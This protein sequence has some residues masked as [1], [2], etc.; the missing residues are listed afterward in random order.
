M[1]QKL[2]RLSEKDEDSLDNSDC[3]E[4]TGDTQQTEVAEQD[5]GKQQDDGSFVTPR[6]MGEISGISGSSL[7]TGKA[8]EHTVTSP[9]TDPQ[10]GQPI[11]P[12]GQ[13]EHPLNTRT[14]WVGG[15]SRNTEKSK[16]VPRAKETRQTFGKKQGS[17]NKAVACAGTTAMEKSATCNPTTEEDFVVLEKDETWTSPERENDIVLRHRINTE[18]PESL[19]KRGSKE[20]TPDICNDDNFVHPSK[21]TPR[22]KGNEKKSRGNSDTLLMG[23]DTHARTSPTVCFKREMGQR[24]AEVTGSRCQL[25]GAGCVGAGAQSETTGSGIAEGEQNLRDHTKEKV[26][27]DIQQEHLSTLN[28]S[29]S[30]DKESH[31]SGF[32]AQR[33]QVDQSYQNRFAGAVYKRA[34]AGVTGIVSA[35]TKKDDSQDVGKAA[36]SITLLLQDN[37]P[38]TVEECDLIPSPP[39]PENGGC[40]GK[41]QVASLK[42]ESEL[43]CFSAVITPPPLTHVMPNRDTT[44]MKQLD[45][46]AVS[47][48]MAPDATSNKGES[49]TKE[50]PKIKGPPP[51]VPKKPKNPFIKLKTAQLMSTDVQR[52][53]KEHLR[54]EER[55]KRRHTFHFNRDLPCST[56]ANQDMCLLWDEKGTYTVPANIR[57]LSA[58]L[59]PW[60]HLS[61]RHMDDRYGDMIDFE[62]CVRMANL[63]PE[64]E[65][66]NLDMWQ[67]RVFPERRTRSKW[68]PP[69]Y[70]QKPSNPFETLPK[71]E[72]TA[73]NEGERP[74][75]ASSGKKEIDPEVQPETVH[76]QVSDHNHVNYAYHRDISDR[77]TERDAGNG[78]EIGSYKPVAKIIREANQM[79]RHQAE[80][81]PEGSK[82]P[83]RVSEQSPSIKVS[84]MKNAFD[85]PKKSKERPAEVQQSPK[86]GKFL[87]IFYQTIY[88]SN[89]VD[90]HL[91]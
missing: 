37:P 62:Y 54:S 65:T 21:N 75:P 13:K 26:S 27:T 5:E 29:K 63:S 84:Q 41:I 17:E 69:P 73:E 10:S 56:L 88:A 60:D 78:S 8:W 47:S 57:R 50:K 42:K 40:D 2:E 87:H 31:S 35:C 64:E 33:Q 90:F 23:A 32:L 81:G 6:G 86:K 34:K 20:D 68:S 52:R 22:E 80:R 58:D 7:A 36:N 43:V 79:Q 11:R 91:K 28:K 67:K 44:M 15:V 66:Q 38:F 85:V 46:N 59:S 24:L 72:V 48:T 71:P 74:N 76:T 53:G 51:P 61:L 82:A 45:T 25:K 16:T 39:L 3:S 14:E 30:Q 83:V 77:S 89:N 9:W 49:V 1:G 55:V 4:Q 70:A 12:L 18:K 19:N